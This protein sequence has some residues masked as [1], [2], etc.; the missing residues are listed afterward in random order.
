M[1][2]TQF[3]VMTLFIAGLLAAFNIGAAPHDVM[4]LPVDLASWDHNQLM[5]GLMMAGTVGSPDFVMK[6]LDKVE[7]QIDDFQ[8]QAKREI[9]ESS[10]ISTETKNALENIGLKQKELADEILLIKQK[11]EARGV[12]T[13]S[14][15]DGWGKQIIRNRAFDEFARGDRQKAKFEIKNNTVTG[16]PT[17]VGADR[18]PGVI[19]GAFSPLKVEA[20]FKH[21]PTGS[22]MIE[23]VRE[24]VFTNSA[25]ETSEA[26]A[27]PESSVTF[28]LVQQPVSTVTHWVKISKQLAADNVALAE[29]INTRLM[30][31]VQKRADSQIVGGNGVA[32]NMNGLLSSGNYVAHG[33]TAAGVGTPLAKHRLIRKVISDLRS[34]GYEPNVVL[35]NPADW[36]AFDLDLLASTPAALS[37]QDIAKGFLPMLFG[38]PVVESNAVTADT[39]VVMDSMAA[40]SIYDRQDVA[41]EISDS[42]SDNFTKNLITVKAERRLVLAVEQVAA[43]RG[44]DLTPI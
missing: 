15:N 21:V 42:D 26:A 17:T 36:L 11:A 43:I 9:Q 8:M 18:I 28:T 37:S 29:Y 31:G 40:G 22:N 25:A 38:V 34:A 44:G 14:V 35:L 12:E 10:R 5:T 13:S 24:N 6:M 19:P 3:I 2:H 7:K 33:Y 27:G 20:L 1:K 39:F 23:Y 41:I 32:P 16:T 30:W 4:A